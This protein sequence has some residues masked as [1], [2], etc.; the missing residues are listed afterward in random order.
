MQKKK[1]E[2]NFQ[3]SPVINTT[4]IATTIDVTVP[5]IPSAAIR[6]SES[7]KQNEYLNYVQ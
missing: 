7:W 4:S 1:N 6:I 2:Q 5:Y 3:E